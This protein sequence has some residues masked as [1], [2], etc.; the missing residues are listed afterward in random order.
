ML[1]CCDGKDI[2]I[3]HVWPDSCWAVRTDIGRGRTRVGR[4]ILL[5]WH[6]TVQMSAV[7]YWVDVLFIVPVIGLCPKFTASDTVP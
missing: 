5:C 4:F 6:N 3:L 1:L 7:P 2:S